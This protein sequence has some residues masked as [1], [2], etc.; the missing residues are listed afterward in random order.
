MSQDIHIQRAPVRNLNSSSIIA[1]KIHLI[2]EPAIALLEYLV[3]DLDGIGTWMRLY[4]PLFY[5]DD[6]SNPS[7]FLA[8][9]LPPEPAYYEVQSPDGQ[10]A[11]S[12]A[13]C[14]LSL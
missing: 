7:P 1:G 12:S 2:G 10:K 4:T 9:L 13:L 5:V 11:D 6:T 3:P 8:S 14:V